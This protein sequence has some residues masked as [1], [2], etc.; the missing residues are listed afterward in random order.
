MRTVIILLA[1]LLFGCGKGQ[2]INA[3][4]V[5]VHKVKKTCYNRKI[6]WDVQSGTAKDTVMSHDCSYWEINSPV[7]DQ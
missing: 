7:L 6:I 5:E 1:A 3:G 2:D 4:V